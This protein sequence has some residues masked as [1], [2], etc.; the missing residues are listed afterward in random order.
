VPADD[1][2]FDALVTLFQ[3]GRALRE[4]RQELEQ[5]PAWIEV[6]IHALLALIGRGI[7]R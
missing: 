1:R 6:P 3:I 7:A 5:R 2:T 4:L